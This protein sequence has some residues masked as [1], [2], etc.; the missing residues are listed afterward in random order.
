[1]RTSP[2]GIAAALQLDDISSVGVMTIASSL[3]CSIAAGS[4]MTMNASVTASVNGS[5]NARSRAGQEV[6]DR[7]HAQVFAAPDRK[8][9]AE[10]AEPQ[11]N[12]RGQFV[13]PDQ[14]PMHD[15]ARDHADE[16]DERLDHDQRRAQQLERRARCRDRWRRPAPR[17][18]MHG[19]A[20]TLDVHRHAVAFI[21]VGELVELAVE[22]LGMLE[23][24]GV[25]AVVVPGNP[26]TP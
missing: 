18:R 5:A 3:T 19:R 20:A 10:H 8:R 25:A 17:R 4:S 9:G 16:Q 23:E 22:A 7:I 2:A 15:V 12:R 14:R 21:A 6:D 1:M 13:G 24:W 11:E 26:A